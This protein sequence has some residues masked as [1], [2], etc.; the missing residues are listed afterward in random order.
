MSNPAEE[1]FRHFSNI[2]RRRNQND[3]HRTS[4][5]QNRFGQGVFVTMGDMLRR[6]MSEMNTEHAETNPV[7]QEAMNT[8]TSDAF[9]GDIQEDGR[10]NGNCSV[11]QD[12]F[13][14]AD[15]ASLPVSSLKELAE[16]FSIPWVGLEKKDLI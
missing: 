16:N 2:S 3:S 9:M 4:N 6:V 14:P 1:F 7:S 13:L 8:K 15:I 11:C 12:S 10:D 5:F